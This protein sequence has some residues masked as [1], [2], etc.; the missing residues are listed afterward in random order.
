[1]KQVD[2]FRS[3]DLVNPYE[4]KRILDQV[5]NVNKSFVAHPKKNCSVCGG[6]R[7]HWSSNRGKT[8]ECK[9]HQK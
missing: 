5:A 4:K 1:M 6:D 3:Y 7:A 8:W 2:L 9:E